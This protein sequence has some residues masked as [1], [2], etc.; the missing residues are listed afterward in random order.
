MTTVS[1]GTLAQATAVTIFAPFFAIPPGL[2]VAAHH[3]SADVLQEEQ[4]DPALVAQFDEVRPFSA[5]S[6]NN[7]RCWRRCRPA[8]P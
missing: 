6:E 7:P 1:F 3:E 8:D 2:V 4:R 5:D